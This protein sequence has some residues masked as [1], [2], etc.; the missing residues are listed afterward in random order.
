MRSRGGRGESYTKDVEKHFDPLRDHEVV[1]MARTLYRT[2]S[3]SYDACMSMAV[4]LTDVEALREKVPFDP[5]PEGLDGRWPLDG[6]REFIAA[7]RQFA[8]KAKFPQFVDAHRRLY[9]TAESRFKALLEKE[10]HLEWFDEFFGPRPQASFTVALGLLNGGQC[11]GPHCR[12]ADG[13]EELYCILGVWRTDQSGLPAFDGSMLETV[14]HEFCHSYTNAI[15]DRHEAE[16]KPA[17][18]KIFPHV[19]ATMRRQ[20]ADAKRPSKED[21]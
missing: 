16:F 17:A 12:T 1:R 3:V 9:E 11:Y 2:R 8:E 5:R 6:A 15:V 14:V 18:E 19:A 13:K 7:A 20:A 21:K 4:H 10:A